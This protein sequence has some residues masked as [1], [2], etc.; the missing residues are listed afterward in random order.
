MTEDNRKYGILV[1]PA[2]QMPELL[3]STGAS[4]PNIYSLKEV[5]AELA[6]RRRSDATHVGSSPENY[7][8]SHAAT[9]YTLVEFRENGTY[10]PVSKFEEGNLA[11]LTQ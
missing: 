4:Q 6:Y 7:S 11:K 2:Q 1:A 9:S 3:Q 10:R 8:K 5:M